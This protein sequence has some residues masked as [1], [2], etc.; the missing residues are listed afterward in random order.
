IS[1][2]E[3]AVP[4][5]V[6]PPAVADPLAGGVKRGLAMAP[7]PRPDAAS[8]EGAPD[9]QRISRVLDLEEA[10]PLAAALVGLVQHHRELPVESLE[11]HG[12]SPSLVEQWLRLL[13]PWAG[14]LS[15]GGF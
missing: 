8:R 13:H 5:E 6:P 7:G 15:R 3:I 4:P 2:S 1:V 10:R 12:M 9:A 14:Q 11:E